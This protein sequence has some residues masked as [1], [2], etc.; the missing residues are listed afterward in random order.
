MKRMGDI[1]ANSRICRGLASM[2]HVLHAWW[3][4]GL[5]ARAGGGLQ[6]AYANSASFRLWQCFGVGPDHYQQSLTYRDFRR[7]AA[8]WQGFGRRLEESLTCRGLRAIGRGWQWL[9]DRSRLIALLSRLSLHQ[10]LLVAFGLYLPLEFLI[11]DTLQL[12]FLSSIWEEL[13]LLAAAV[14][15]L[16]RRALRA[17]DA[18]RRETPLD[19]WLLLFFAVGFFLMSVVRPYPGVAL[20]GYRIV[21][22]YMLW[23]FLIVRLVEDDR[24]LKV[25]YVSLL[26]MSGFLALH[27]VYQ[28]AVGVEIPVS[29]VSQTEMGV[30][31]RVFSLTGSPNILGS[32]LVL[33]APLVAAMI[34][35]CR[36]VWLKVVAFGLTGCYILSLLFTFS[37]G[38]WVGMIAAV[39][40]FALFIDKRLL[41][42]MGAAMAGLLIC[43]PSITGRLT[44]LFTED[45]AVASAIGGR[46]LRWQVGLQLLHEHN[47]WLGFGLGRF[48][49][50][51][52]MENKLLDET[53]EFSYFY[54]DNYYLKTL[55][56]MGYLGLIAFLL[57]ILAL[58]V[59]GMRAIYRSD[60]SFNGQ[61]ALG[62]DPLWRAVGNMRLIAV[63]IY[64]GLVGVLVHCYFENIF[65]EPYMAAYFWGLAAVLMYL[66]YFRKQKPAP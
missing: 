48:G 44:Y 34:Y 1:M 63:A 5:L 36:R 29:W 49:G 17:T 52:A 46:T 23:F 11:R 59:L 6:R 4:Q 54:M 25:L 61:G 9:A 51:V 24:D 15:V 26:L 20:P 40:I 41:A 16:W 21:V 47:P 53:E 64:S 8:L 7:L 32:L 33:T 27:G 28:Y 42:I 65:E 45:Y 13:F 55:V 50:A 60:L 58:L 37:R 39:V 10:W 19:I 62:R 66:G 12:G 22:E 2:G 18:I 38:A 57:L 31:T 43:V 30:R 3:R 35:F 14:L 56:E